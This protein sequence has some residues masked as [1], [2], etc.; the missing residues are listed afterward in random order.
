MSQWLVSMNHPAVY[1]RKW[2]QYH[3]R[4]RIFLVALVAYVPGVLIVGWFLR[5]VT[6]LSSWN[7]GLIAFVIFGGCATA[8]MF[9]LERW[10]CLRCGESVCRWAG[11]HW[12]FAVR[13][14]TLRTPKI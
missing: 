13:C 9:N 6:S 5:T 1:S 2:D 4:Q 14:F 11:M 3:R 12:P 10:R 8:A 7:A